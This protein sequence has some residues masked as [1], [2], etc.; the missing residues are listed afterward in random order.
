MTVTPLYAGL[1]ALLYVLL[2]VNVIRTRFAEKISTGDDG[3]AALI[4]SMRV[5]ANFAEYA[6]FGVVLLALAE[7]QGAPGIAVHVLGLMLLAGRGLHAWGFGSTPQ[8]IPA[9]RAGMVLTF[10]M[11]TL[12]GLANIGHVLF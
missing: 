10:A 6:P 12:T 1:L 8:V 4:K 2:S 9:R 7:L 11:L 5:H 3:N